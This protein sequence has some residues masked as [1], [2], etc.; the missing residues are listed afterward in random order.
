MLSQFFIIPMKFSNLSKQSFAAAQEATE[1]FA[2]NHMGLLGS[3]CVCVCAH[4][5]MCC[6]MYRQ[7]G[8]I[9]LSWTDCPDWKSTTGGTAA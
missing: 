2:G 7:V 9:A 4:V 5:S 6:E 1:P 8:N 3:L